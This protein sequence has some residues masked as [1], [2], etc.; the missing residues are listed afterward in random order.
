MIILII[1]YDNL[2]IAA[3]KIIIAVNP[4]ETEVTIQTYCSVRVHR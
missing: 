3:H 4:L 1:E 2:Q